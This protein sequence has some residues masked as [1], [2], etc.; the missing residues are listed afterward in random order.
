[1]VTLWKYLLDCNW[2]DESNYKTKL[3]TQ[4]TIVYLCKI[5]VS[6]Y[7]NNTLRTHFCSKT[8]NKNKK[9]CRESSHQ[10]YRD[11]L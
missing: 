5:T 8:Q 2:N 4:L 11:N 3:R 1:M 7:L 6:G 10:H 9:L